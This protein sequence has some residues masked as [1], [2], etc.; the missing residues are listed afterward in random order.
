MSDEKTSWEMF[1]VI[2]GL[3]GITSKM[4]DYFK[5]LL[6]KLIPLPRVIFKNIK[7]NLYKSRE[8]NGNI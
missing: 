2:D 5:Q 4:A 3:K 7:K 1:G 6:D 8:F